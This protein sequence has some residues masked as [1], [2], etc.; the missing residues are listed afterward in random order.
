MAEPRHRGGAAALDLVTEAV[1]AVRGR[2]LRSALTLLGVA[3]GILALVATVGL[4]GSAAAQVSARF[5]ALKA[6]RI[7]V[8]GFSGAAGAP[9][10][11]ATGLRGPVIGPDALERARR[12]NGVVA[13]GTVAL[14]GD[15]LPRAGRPGDR[16]PSAA[17]ETQVMAADPDALRA[18]RIRPVSG[19]LYDPVHQDLRHRVL[20][21][22][23]VAAR[24]LGLNPAD[25]SI[26]DGRTVIHLAGRPYLLLGIV[27]TADFD[28]Q[29]QLSAIVPEWVARDPT[30]KIS[31][32]EPKVVVQTRPGA[33]RQVGTEAKVALD[34]AQ[35]DQLVAQ[36][37]PDPERLRAG[38]ETDTRTLF[39]VMAAVS[40][41][42]SA[43]GIGNTTL[44][45]VLERRHEIGLRRAIGASRRS[46]LVQFLLESGVLG[47]LGGVA[48]TIGG[49]DLTIAISL[50][51]G[52]TAAIS[53]WL[54]VVG[55]LL[56]LTVGLVAGVYPAAK[57][58]RMEP[59][60]AL[61]T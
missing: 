22:G 11:T 33:A 14:A 26:A 32:Q 27:T 56:G 37:P 40:L 39:L 20:L 43:I 6:T 3:F 34:P 5:D 25:H 44:V 51:R 28:S 2:R 15:P 18:L 38:V 12:L 1:E 29:A 41:L 52:W 57:A 13:A 9:I 42:I 50:A 45:A 61:A 30:S 36:V 24:N 49:L 60:A 23:D 4:T 21:L 55:P 48:G 16:V 17:V 53:P 8:E 10:D 31:F 58:A 35:P 19:R 46:I 54:L 7:S 47:L 59:V